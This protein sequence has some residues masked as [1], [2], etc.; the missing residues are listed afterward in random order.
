MPRAAAF[1]ERVVLTAADAGLRALAAQMA[2]DEDE[3]VAL[4]E[5]M[6]E[7]TPPVTDWA[8]IYE[9]EPT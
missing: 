2:A 8:S 5:Q 4:L 7:T 1:F 3:H 6:L 9:R